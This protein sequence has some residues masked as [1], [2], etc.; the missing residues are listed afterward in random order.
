MLEEAH[1]VL[2][3][4][5]VMATLLD[6]HDPYEEPDWD[7]YERLCISIINQ[8]L[9]TAS[10]TAVRERVFDRLEGE[11]TPETVLA[12]DDGALRDAGLSRSKVEYLR[13]AARAFQNGDFSRSGLA[14]HSNDEVIDLLTE[15]RGIGEWTARMYLL[16][17]LERPD[18]LPLGD[19][20]VRRGIEQLYA[21]GEELTRA[22]MREIAEAWRPYR[23]VATRYI[24]AE[25]ES[26]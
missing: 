8:Q 1:S 19:L 24:W 12:A 17:V 23:S 18:V 7:E 21:N 2:R 5:P 22:Q 9:S 15:I 14:N 3:D 11:V 26:E 16:F 6:R 20:A 25:Y 4:D 13:N 10:A